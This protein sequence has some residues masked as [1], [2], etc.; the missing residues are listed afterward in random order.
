MSDIISNPY[1]YLQLLAAAEQAAAC[2]M[3]EQEKAIIA[4][5]DV[6]WRE[7][8]PEEREEV[9]KRLGMNLHFHN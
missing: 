1:Y 6:L 7:M 4:E 3:E 9:D 2:Q 5:M 8:T